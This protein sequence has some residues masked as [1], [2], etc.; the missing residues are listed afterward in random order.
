[1]VFWCIFS[2]LHYFRKAILLGAGLM[3]VVILAVSIWDRAVV[4]YVRDA[5]S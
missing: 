5:D 2:V 1:M 3:I 4:N